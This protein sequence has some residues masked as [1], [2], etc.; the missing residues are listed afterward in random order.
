MSESIEYDGV[1]EVNNDFFFHILFNAFYSGACITWIPF[2][3]LSLLAKIP[4][5]SRVRYFTF[6]SHLRWRRR[7]LGS[8]GLRKGSVEEMFLVNLS[9]K[10][11]SNRS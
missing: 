2:S 9:K 4:V 6:P 11:Y 1:V 3:S 10:Q 5:E 8:D 7:S